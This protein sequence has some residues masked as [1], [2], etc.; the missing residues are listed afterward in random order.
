MFMLQVADGF[1]FIRQF[2]TQFF[3]YAEL[4]GIYGVVL[5]IRFIHIGQ[6]K[7]S[8]P[9]GPVFCELPFR[10]RLRNQAPKLTLW[11]C[12]PQAH[13]LVE[14]IGNQLGTERDGAKAAIN[15]K[16]FDVTLF[17][18]RFTYAVYFVQLCLR[19]RRAQ[20]ACVRV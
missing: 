15:G 7:R 1:K 13:W 16:A 12:L 14:H 17:A 19:W 18:Q 5:F 3:K 10:W 4:V 9:P 11:N 2:G 8:W 6:L 20:N